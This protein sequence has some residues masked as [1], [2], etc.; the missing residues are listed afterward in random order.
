MSPN[1][2]KCRHFNNDILKLKSAGFR[3][4]SMV[5]S[6]SMQQNAEWEPYC[7][8]LFWPIAIFEDGLDTVLLEVKGR[9]NEFP[10]FFQPMILFVHRASRPIK[11][12]A[13]WKLNSKENWDYWS[14]K[15]E[16]FKWAIL[17]YNTHWKMAMICQ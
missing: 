17:Y 15:Y 5:V 6:S 11:V 9:L 1:N 8:F 14:K 10:M 4:R 16:S 2:I 3:K 12:E 7:L 13:A